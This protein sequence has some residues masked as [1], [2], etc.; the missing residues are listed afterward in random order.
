MLRNSHI[1]ISIYS[2]HYTDILQQGMP[3]RPM[4][5]G[6]PMAA[7]G[8]PGMMPMAGVMQQQPQQQSPAGTMMAPQSAPDQNG[9][10]IQLD[11]FGAF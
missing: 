10:N 4:M 3:I 2:S 1:S 11:P 6:A 8:Q 7:S 5:S 9:K